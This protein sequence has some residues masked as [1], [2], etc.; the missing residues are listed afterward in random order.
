MIKDFLNDDK[1]FALSHCKILYENLNKPCTVSPMCFG[2]EFGPGWNRVMKELSVKLEMLNIIFYRS[3][4]VKIILDQCKEKY[5]MLTVYYSVDI[6]S[7]FYYTM[8]R[9]PFK[10]ISKF[11]S[12][13]FDFKSKLV[14]DEEEK[15]IPTYEHINDSDVD[16]MKKLYEGVS[17]IRFEK[18][19]DGW[20][21]VTDTTYCRRTHMEPTKHLVV[22]HI[23]SLIDQLSSL[24]TFEKKPSNEQYL[25]REAVDNIAS[26]L[27]CNAEKQCFNVCEMC[28][29]RIGTSKSKRIETSG[30]IS[31][32]CE[33]CDISKKLQD[34]LKYISD[35]ITKTS[36]ILTQDENDVMKYTQN[37]LSKIEESGYG[38]DFSIDNAKS[39][40]E[41]LNKIYK[42]IKN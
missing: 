18:T 41:K 25:V 21:K 30:W 37:E 6:E 38:F 19:D 27:I 23:K 26:E 42:R 9:K 36:N 10:Y 1:E 33:W 15:V 2:W 13:H 20:M 40:L 5:G 35:N 12:K 22:Y 28:G 16:K 3:H 39:T 4:R 14:V 32:I 29:D 7:P 24:F 8:W 34:N 31:Y 17:Y 11:I